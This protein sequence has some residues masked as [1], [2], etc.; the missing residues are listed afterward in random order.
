MS[1]AL[2]I[3]GTETVTRRSRRERPEREVHREAEAPAAVIEGMAE[4]MTPEAA[5]ADTRQQL[6]QQDRTVAEERR[7]R[8]EAEQRAQAAERRVGQAEAVRATDRQSVVASA[9]EAAKAEQ[10]NARAQLKAAM[11]MGDSDGV[12]QATE[13]LSGAT[14]RLSQSTAE[15]EW[16][17]NQPKPQPG[18]TQEHKPTG[19]AQR[20]L[21]EH[22]AFHSDDAYRSTAEGA[23][24]AA[25]RA[26]KA[27][28]SEAY[29][30][31]IED[32]MVRVYGE[33]HGQAGTSNNDGGKPMNRGARGDA[34]P[35]SRGASSGSG[36]WQKIRTPAG[37]LLVQK[38]AD[39]SKGIKF[40]SADQ[41]SAFQ[42]FAELAKMSLAEYAAD[43]LE[44]AD[45]I[46]AGG[47][48]DFVR[49][50]GETFR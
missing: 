10:T 28:G 4:N 7:L 46:A 49:G 9:L 50:D 19:R 48:G 45:E 41:Q 34:V 14:F 11:E 12:A 15:L 17:K 5:L 35:P 24:N 32:I 31:H 33:G 30:Q 22:P 13:S 26:G 6:E 27:E 44:I 47:S 21:D 1:E 23:H 43:Q 39:G 36:G 2:N 38:R 20:W 40:T 8:R 18:A 37:E 42:E 29:I 25:V 3:P 16:L